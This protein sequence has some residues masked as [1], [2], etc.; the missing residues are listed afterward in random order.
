VICLFSNHFARLF[1]FFVYRLLFVVLTLSKYFTS[2]F[3]VFYYKMDMIG[4]GI[5]KVFEQ[6]IMNDKKMGKALGG[7]ILLMIV[8]VFIMKVFIVKWAYNTIMPRLIVNNG[9]SI[10]NFKPLSTM[11]SI[12]VVV[13][14]HFLLH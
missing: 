7:S 8:L 9:N 3:N 4:G 1:T 12:V 5:S 2:N 6:S 11:E 13:L 14:F 10:Q